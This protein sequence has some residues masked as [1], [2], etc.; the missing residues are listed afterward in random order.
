ML[1]HDLNTVTMHVTNATFVTTQVMQERVKYSPILGLVLV[2][3]Q[4]SFGPDYFRFNWV[5]V[6]FKSSFGSVLD[7]VQ[8]SFSGGFVQLVQSSPD[9][10]QF[11]SNSTPHFVQ[12]QYSFCLLLVQFKFSF[13]FSSS[14][15]LVHIKSRIIQM[16]RVNILLKSANKD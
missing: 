16:R 11:Q 7:Q 15:H 10:V 5:S 3:F 6:K 14:L 1:W 12:F 4:S 9:S 8:T 13:V 2:L